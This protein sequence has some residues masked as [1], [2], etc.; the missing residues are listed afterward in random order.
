MGWESA[1]WN[2]EGF[3]RVLWGVSCQSFEENFIRDHF[4]K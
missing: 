1:E 4:V 2:E 3:G